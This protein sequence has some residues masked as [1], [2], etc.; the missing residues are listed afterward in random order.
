MKNCKKVCE[1][2]RRKNTIQEHR[3]LGPNF[4][5][6]IQTAVFSTHWVSGL[7][8][9]SGCVWAIMDGDCT[10]SGYV[11][12]A[13]VHSPKRKPKRGGQQNNYLILWKLTLLSWQQNSSLV[14]IWW[15][16]YFSMFRVLHGYKLSTWK[17][18]GILTVFSE[19][20]LHIPHIKGEL[21]FYFSQS[22]NNQLID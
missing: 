14:L 9:L 6:K 1:E 13:V 11:P 10:V 3:C 15:W 18:T 12:S 21:Y 22:W 17:I 16:T 2:K 5:L 8:D 19:Y 20:L 7:D 4:T